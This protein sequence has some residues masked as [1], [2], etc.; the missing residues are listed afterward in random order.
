MIC[1]SVSQSLW[2]SQPSSP[3]PLENQLGTPRLGTSVY[4]VG[5]WVNCF[6]WS[7]SQKSMNSGRE[8]SAL[9]EGLLNYWLQRECFLF[10]LRGVRGLGLWISLMPPLFL[11]QFKLCLQVLPTGTSS[12]DIKVFSNVKP[13]REKHLPCE[14]TIFNNILQANITHT[15]SVMSHLWDSQFLP[16]KL[17]KLVQ[18]PSIAVSHVTMWLIVN[19][20]LSGYG[21]AKVTITTQHSIDAAATSC[22]AFSELD[23]GNGLAHGSPVFSTWLQTASNAICQFRHINVACCSGSP[24]I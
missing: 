1:C 16:A 7:R 6:S 24:I 20:A 12:S 21:E 4:R 2:L 9:C 11:P 10:K 19:V 13:S 5:C 22:R 14:G 17:S 8:K 18:L 3:R 15:S 23:W